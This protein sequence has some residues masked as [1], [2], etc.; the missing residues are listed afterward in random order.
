[1]QKRFEQPTRQSSFAI[2]FILGR[3]FRVL[4]RQLWI[5]I[6]VLLFNP[7]KQVFNSFTLFVIGMAGLGS[8][9]SIISYFRL[10]FYIR[11][12]ELVLEKGVLRRKKITVP[13]DRIQSVNFKQG[14]LHQVLNVV[15]IEI[16]TAGSTGNEFSLEAL[17]KRRCRGFAAGI[18]TILCFSHPSSRTGNRC[19]RRIHYWPRSATNTHDSRQKRVI[20]PVESGGF[21]ENR[22][23]SK[24]RPD[25]RDYHGLFSQFLR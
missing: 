22:G 12:D 19:H 5:L 18:D 16:D 25:G 14:V 2:I 1:M 23:E 9:T 15:S 11:D 8:I 4:F 13:I 21:G 3:T 10:Y 20:V 6:L 17:K 24:P 7:K